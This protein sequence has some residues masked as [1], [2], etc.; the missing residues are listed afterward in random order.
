[1]TELPPLH[2]SCSC[3]YSYFGDVGSRDKDLWSESVFCGSCH[4]QLVKGGYVN[5]DYAE[6]EIWV[7]KVTNLKA[8]ELGPDEM[9]RFLEQLSDATNN[10]LCG[11][12]FLIIHHYL[13]ISLCINVTGRYCLNC[14]V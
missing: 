1:M 13:F 12:D 14:V 8:V 10:I 7:S 6:N 5:Y 4:D 2:P 9:G 11:S 3:S